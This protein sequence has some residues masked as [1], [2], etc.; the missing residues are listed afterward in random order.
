MSTIFFS[1]CYLYLHR[2][3]TIGSPYI[4]ISCKRANLTSCISALIHAGIEANKAVLD[5]V[6]ATVMEIRQLRNKAQS[7]VQELLKKGTDQ[8]QEK[9]GAV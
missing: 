4:F 6:Y 5:S 3:C 1:S 7:A 2:L 9:P 8:E